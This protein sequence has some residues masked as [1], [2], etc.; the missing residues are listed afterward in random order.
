MSTHP[1]R[2]LIVGGGCFGLSV[3]LALSKD[4]NRLVIVFDRDSIPSRDAAS[5]DTTKAI[6]ADYGD[7]ILYQNLAL[8]ALPLWRMWSKE[9][10]RRYGDNVY[11]ES[12]VLF[13]CRDTWTAYERLSFANLGNSRPEGLRAM[14]GD[15]IRKEF[16][17]FDRQWNTGYLNREGGWCFASRAIQLTADLCQE[18]G[19]KYITGTAGE[20]KE[21]IWSEGRINAK[22][23]H[24]DWELDDLFSPR[25]EGHDCSNRAS[26]HS[27]SIARITPS[28]IPIQC[29][30]HL[31]WRSLQNRSSGIF[32]RMGPFLSVK[33]TF[34]CLLGFYGFPAKSNGDLKIAIHSDGYAYTITTQD[35]ECVSIPR[36]SID[37]PADTIPS[38]AL[39]R[40]RDF[41]RSFLPELAELE[42]TKAK[43]CWYCDSF[44]GNFIVDHH[45]QLPGVFVVAG[46]SGHGMKFLPILGEKVR[47]IL[48]GDADILEKYRT[49]LWRRP[50]GNG[51]LKLNA[52]RVN[53]GTDERKQLSELEMARREEL[54]KG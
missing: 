4:P 15:E 10:L 23:Y 52:S 44:D 26:R 34:F 35:N 14:N 31:V 19:V 42:I 45:P 50:A 24:G 12:G 30:P 8:E 6:R 46:D 2:T 20:F 5:N 27:P 29:I 51:G 36:T 32:H 40:A 28:E 39:A 33:L 25:N 17:Q 48:E 7:H 21:F 3:A 43:L 22:D 47:G 16:P 11:T 1:K 37:H 9:A 49:W 18:Q 41:L 54:N 38:E 53:A 13:L